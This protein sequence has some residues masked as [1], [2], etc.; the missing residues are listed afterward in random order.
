MQG[1]MLPMSLSWTLEVCYNTNFVRCFISPFFNNFTASI[2]SGIGCTG[3]LPDNISGL[4]ECTFLRLNWN[5]IFGSLPTRLGAMNKLVT[6]D[7]SSNMLGG[8]LDAD[9][10]SQFT[11]L[12]NLNLSFN[13]F[14]GPIPDVF[15]CMRELT[16]L[17][18]SG[19]NLIGVIPP[20]ISCLAELQELKLYNNLLSGAIPAEM[21][22]LQNLVR[23]NLSQNRYSQCSSS[24][25][26]SCEV[27]S[28][29]YRHVSCLKIG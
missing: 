6:L 17:N 3:K 18:L 1:I 19:N 27:H 28:S 22:T 24:L 12:K 26:T 13:E 14:E 23:V 8:Y 25:L 21:S 9:S 15:S 16:H 2:T 10:F 29:S 7:L 5:L 4:E 20:S 11:C